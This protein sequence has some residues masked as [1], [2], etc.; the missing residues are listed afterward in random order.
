MGLVSLTAWRARSAGLAAAATR[1]KALIRPALGLSEGDALSVNE[2]VC[3]DPACP[4]IETVVLVMRAGEPTRA[5][6]LPRPLA[7]LSEA[8]ARVLAGEEAA[9]R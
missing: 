4:G 7:E 6:R 9:L 3:A 8:D 2:I 5:L 1:A